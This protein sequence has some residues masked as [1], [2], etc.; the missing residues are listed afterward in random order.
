M[1]SRGVAS[2]RVLVVGSGE[3]ARSIIRTLLARPDLGFS[4]IGYLDDGIG[5]NNIGLGRIPHLGSYRELD[6]V[7]TSP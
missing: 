6:A 5:E 2:D 7:L 4:A 1:Y 3:T